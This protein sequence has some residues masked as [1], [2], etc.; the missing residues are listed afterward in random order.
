[1]K[2][3]ATLRI[4]LFTFFATALY[5]ERANQ[6]LDREQLSVAIVHLKQ[7]KTEITKVDDAA[8]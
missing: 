1:M 6:V 8:N 2:L 5:A 3:K 7:A 4:V